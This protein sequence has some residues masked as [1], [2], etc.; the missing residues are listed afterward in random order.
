MDKF[1]RAIQIVFRCSSQ[2]APRLEAIF[3]LTLYKCLASRTLRK[4][5]IVKSQHDTIVNRN[6]LVTRLETWFWQCLRDKP[7]WSTLE[8]GSRPPRLTFCVMMV[9]GSTNTRTQSSHGCPEEVAFRHDQCSLDPSS[10]YFVKVRK[11]THV[12]ATN[13]PKLSFQK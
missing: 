2:L 4:S 12:G 6:K 5:L 10:Q 1:S 11:Q 13:K 9:P 3:E 7:A 8:L